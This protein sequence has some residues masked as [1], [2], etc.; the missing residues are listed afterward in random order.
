MKG[1]WGITAIVPNMTEVSSL[2]V[3]VAARSSSI[4]VVCQSKKTV[5]DMPLSPEFKI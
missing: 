3:R 2:Q 5:K 4:V 1:R